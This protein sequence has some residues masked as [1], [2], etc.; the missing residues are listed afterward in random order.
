MTLLLPRLG[1]R[2]QF[3]PSRFQQL[4]GDELAPLAPLIKSIGLKRD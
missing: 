2:R 3:Q 1:A 4:V